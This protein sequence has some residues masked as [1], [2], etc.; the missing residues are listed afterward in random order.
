MHILEGGFRVLIVRQRH[1]ADQDL[2]WTYYVRSLNSLELES[3]GE[4]SPRNGKYVPVQT[5]C[6]VLQQT[7]P[8]EIGCLLTF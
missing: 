5:T 2:I 6:Q 1:H 3:G 4:Y 8:K 7:S